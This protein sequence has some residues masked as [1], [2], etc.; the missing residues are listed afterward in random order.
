[1]LSKV[2][3][4]VIATAAAGLAMLGFAAPAQAAQGWVELW[5]HAN[6]DNSGGSNFQWA[7][8]GACVNIDYLENQVSSVKTSRTVILFDGD[9]CSLGSVTV[10][11]ESSYIGWMSDRV[12]SFKII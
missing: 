8:V 4:V 1:M 9:G 5:N 11:R 3:T 6:Y 2:R 10:T 12:N 7:E